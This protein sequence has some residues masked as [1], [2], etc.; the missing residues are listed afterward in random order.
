MLTI[1]TTDGHAIEWHVGEPVPEMWGRSKNF[2]KGLQRIS[3]IQAD[4]H[5]LEH[6]VKLFTSKL[7][8][9]PPAGEGPTSVDFEFPSIPI[10][11]K[12]VCR[13]YGS[14]AKTIFLNL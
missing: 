8:V 4:G 6:I 13:W 10:P 1:N 2:D 7:K 12:P 5:E 11:N 3:F 14:I 9:F